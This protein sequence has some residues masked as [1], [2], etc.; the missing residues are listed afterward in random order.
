[1]EDIVAKRRSEG[2]WIVHD[3]NSDC[4]DLIGDKIAI[5]FESNYRWVENHR[6]IEKDSFQLCDRCSYVKITEMKNED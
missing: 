5:T 1:M 2:D 4:E 6:T 3:L